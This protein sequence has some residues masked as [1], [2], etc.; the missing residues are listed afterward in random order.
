NQLSDVVGI[1]I[2][3][4]EEG[5]GIGDFVSDLVAKAVNSED[6][7]IIENQ[8]EK[9]DHDHLG[10]IITYAS[11][12]GAKYIVWISNKLREEHQKALEWLNENS[13]NNGL[14]FFG[15][16]IETIQID[17][18]K[19]ALDFKI[20][21]EPN[22][23]ERDV[24]Q[25]SE[26]MDERLKKYLLFYTRLVAEYEKIKPEWSHLTPRPDN[27]L[28]FGAGKAGFN[29]NWSFRGNNR[30]DVELFIDTGNQDEIKSYFSGLKKYQKVIN[31]K[32]ANLS[33]EE[34]P[35]RRA[36]RIALYYQMDTSARNMNDR[37][38]DKLIIWAIQKMDL[39]KKVFTE[40]IRKLE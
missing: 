4:I 23:W 27:W 33:W 2:E 34:L 29:F 30:F 11:G 20:I 15:V 8:L 19:P 26:Q 1:E 5:R 24:K 40:Y 14:S 35:E 16:E 10:K 37:Q 32:I 6:K 9:T 22:S 18:S 31:K 17:N 7:I 13:S 21:I 36:S 38:I 28:G 39:F 25:S 12:I 3:N